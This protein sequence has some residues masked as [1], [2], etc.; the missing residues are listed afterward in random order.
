VFP[1]WR[2]RRGTF[3]LSS[4]NAE[5]FNSGVLC[6]LEAHID[7]NNISLFVT[8]HKVDTN[9]CTANCT[10]LVI[11]AFRRKAVVS[12]V[13]PTSNMFNIGSENIKQ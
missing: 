9:A 13:F 8:S 6:R 3:L 4:S 11:A 10:E 7:S 1:I 5:Q 12:Q 2:N